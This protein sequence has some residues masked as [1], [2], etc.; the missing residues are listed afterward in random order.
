[1]Y[2]FQ[3]SYFSIKLF[4]RYYCSL[5]SAVLITPFLIWMTL[6]L[7]F[8]MISLARDLSSLLPFSRATFWFASKQFPY[9]SFSFHWFPFIII[10]FLLPTLGLLCSSFSWS[11]TLVVAIRAF[12][13]Q[14]NCLKQCFFPLTTA[15][16]ASHRFWYVVFSLSFDSKYFLTILLISSLT[17][18]YYL[19][20]KYL[21]FSKIR[22]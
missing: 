3:Y 13:F 7:S 11:E 21:G 2:S 1:M 12:F 10:S 15:L 16:A 9:C 17:C 18:D 14:Y 6:F 22:Y 8:F 20:S 4:L 19:I 5:I